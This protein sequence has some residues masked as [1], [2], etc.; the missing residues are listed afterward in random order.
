MHAVVAN[1]LETR[2]QRVIVVTSD[3]ERLVEREPAQAD[4]EIPLVDFLITL[5]TAYIKADAGFL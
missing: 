2:K 1:E 5:Q 3:G 4:V